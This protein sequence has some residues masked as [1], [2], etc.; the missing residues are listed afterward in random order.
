MRNRSVALIAISV[1]GLGA[2]SSAGSALG[3]TTAQ[4]IVNGVNTGSHPVS[5][6]QTG[7]MWHIQTVDESPGFSAFID[8]GDT[9]GANSVR[10]L[11]L[12]DFTGSYWQGII[13]DGT[14]SIKNG[15]FTLKGTAQG[16]FAKS[17]TKRAKV[18]YEITTDCGTGKTT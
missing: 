17:P 15:T 1:V 9:V 11:Q 5:C 12:A 10:L 16:A 8:T 2:C 13:G 18:P 7:W 14:A 6:S 3:H 4:V